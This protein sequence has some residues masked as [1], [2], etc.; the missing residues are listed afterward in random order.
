MRLKTLVCP[1]EDSH[2]SVWW[3]CGGCRPLWSTAAVFLYRGTKLTITFPTPINDDP[4]LP[5]LIPTHRSYI[6]LCQPKPTKNFLQVTPSLTQVSNISQEKNICKRKG[7]F[8]SHLSSCGTSDVSCNPSMSYLWVGNHCSTVD[9]KQWWKV[10]EFI[11][12][13]HLNTINKS[14]LVSIIII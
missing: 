6:T 11:R 4:I 10:S 14:F 13:L 9:K 3:G 7:S 5:L 2:H 8:Q 1:R 12:V